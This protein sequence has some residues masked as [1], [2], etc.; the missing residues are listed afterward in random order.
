MTIKIWNFSENGKAYNKTEQEIL[1]VEML[2]TFTQTGKTPK[3]NKKG[4]MS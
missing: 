3:A 2:K 1:S 4:W